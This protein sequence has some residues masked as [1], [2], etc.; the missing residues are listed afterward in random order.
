MD[1]FFFL[2]ICLSHIVFVSQSYFLVQRKD[3]EL[4]GIAGSGTEE[5]RRT[6]K[7]QF[8]TSASAKLNARFSWKEN[9]K[10]L[11][12]VKKNTFRYHGQWNESETSLQNFIWIQFSSQKKKVN[13]KDFGFTLTWEKFQRN[14]FTYLV[15]FLFLHPKKHQSWSQASSGI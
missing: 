6:L 10:S 13:F 14:F 1:F 11:L 7:C 15:I 9:L 5:V 12:H 8:Y 3:D 2:K 4:Y